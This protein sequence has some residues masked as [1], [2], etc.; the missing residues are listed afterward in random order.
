MC[1]FVLLSAAVP[2]T[3][4][5]AEQG[6][7]TEKTGSGED[8]L[9][10]NKENWGTRRWQWV[11]A[12]V[13]VPEMVPGKGGFKEQ[14]VH[15]KSVAQ[16][17]WLA[18]EVWREKVN[19]FCFTYVLHPWYSVTHQAG[20]RPTEGTSRKLLEIKPGMHGGLSRQSWVHC[21]GWEA[22]WLM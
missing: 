5:S 8:F 9:F 1:L 6:P 21:A 19:T 18:A 20:W 15:C 3:V 7:P 14:G 2:G 12:A 13:I 11:T 16:C 17:T 22:A 10:I 4:Q